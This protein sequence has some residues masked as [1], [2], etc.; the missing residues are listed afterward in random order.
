MAI[1]RDL[2]L[3]FIHV[4]KTGGSSVET[5]LG[6]RG[7]WRVEDRST[8]FGQISSPDL[9]ALGLGSA[10]LTHLTLAEA[11]ALVGET[12]PLTSFSFVRNPWDRVVSTYH[13]IDKHMLW[14]ARDGGIELTGLTFAEFVPRLLE[15]V[16]AHTVPQARYVTIDGRVAV[17]RL[18]RYETLAA[19]FAALAAAF[20]IVATLPSVNLGTPRAHPD[21]RAYYD[22]T[23]RRAVGRFYEEDCDL[24]GYVFDPGTSSG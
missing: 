9:V 10:F 23:L 17:D 14:Q 18:G 19:D 11:R 16:H 2:G 4:P 21:Y 13:R 12:G 7:D 20:G 15:I 22:D 6:L 24:F 5:A 8:L 3:L 1:D